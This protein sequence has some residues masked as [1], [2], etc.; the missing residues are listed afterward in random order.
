MLD[1]MLAQQIQETH[2]LLE[3]EG[4]V[5]SKD[6]LEE[7]YRTFRER[8]GP[9]RLQALDGAALLEYM[10]AHGNRDSLVYWLE[11]K[12]DEEFPAI[13][14]SIAG[15][16]ALKFGVFKSAQ[17]GEWMSRDQ[18]NYPTPIPIDDAI[19]IA[20]EHRAQLFRG[21]R[22][23]EELPQNG[24]DEDYLA[25]QEAMNTQ[26]PD[27]SHLAWG[28][29][30]FSLLHPD[31]LDDYHVESFQ[32]F[33]LIK[34]LQIPPDGE[35]RYLC[36]GRFVAIARDLDMPIN[37]LT[38]VLNQRNGRPHQ[39]WRIGTV[40]DPERVS[41]DIWSEMRDGNFVA[42]GWDKLGDLSEQFDDPRTVVDGLK[43][44]LA[45]HHPSSQSVIT[46]K[47][48][49]IRRFI[50][51][52]GESAYLSNGDLVLPS[53]G[54][55]V[56]GIGRVIGD[57][58]YADSSPFPHR[59]PVE[60]LDLSE[61]QM[62][63]QDGLRTT[64]WELKKYPANL[65][66]IEERVLHTDGVTPEPAPRHPKPLLDSI[67]GH[68]QAILERKGQV[69][70]YGPPGTGKTYWA[71]RTARDLAAYSA[72]DQRFEELDADRQR[73]VSNRYVRLCTFHPGYGYEDF[74]EGYRPELAN[75][76]MAFVHRDGIFKDLCAAAQAEPNRNF[77]LII[78]E[79]N[80][81][82]IPRIFGE[83]ITLLEK[84]KRSKVVHLPL[85]GRPFAVPRNVLVIGTMN[86]ADRSIALL[87]TA[88]RRRFG[89]VELMPDYTLLED[90]MIEGIPLG[91][92]LDALNRQIVDHVGR[93]ARNLQIGHAYFMPDGKPVTSFT[94]F[95]QILRE[96]ILPL[97]Q[98]YCYEDYQTLELILGS[99]LVDAHRQT[100]QHDLFAPE[101]QDDLIQALLAPFP[102]I[103]TTPQAAA[104]E[105]SEEEAEE[106]IED[107]DLE[108]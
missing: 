96:D 101:R 86:T 67:A 76:Q 79:I 22:L 78:D 72:F 51:L 26:A 52:G 40:L 3:S 29:K 47:A 1:S 12:N 104:S 55:T 34:L 75:G 9:D 14:G 88:L 90:T 92:W 65:V 81:G 58:K 25:L 89:F 16:S 84:D 36:A 103:T 99:G 43:E 91:P 19:A 53:N 106:E 7:Y 56:L 54:R 80:R 50:N 94:R 95:A 49:E 13:F 21:L 83:L 20:R 35:G 11:F 45:I 82:D 42:I 2:Q 105:Q 27:V 98:E 85:S 66:A 32:R 4:R 61:W 100:I 28:H 6:R 48:N 44:L 24:A 46:R 8:F 87:D 39:Y 57:Y 38:T 10:H 37:H 107:E 60:W 64:V 102:D 97:L 68:I 74:L 77:Y 23:L 17:T 33:H 71:E 59:R 93:D 31:K 70:L 18:R 30:Y 73:E 5:P 63:H 41:L 108:G 69:I 62:P 15:G